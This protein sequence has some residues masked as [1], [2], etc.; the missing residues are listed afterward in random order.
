MNSFFPKG[1]LK[2]SQKLEAL[3]AQRHKKPSVVYLVTSAS[4][5][6]GPIH[7]FKLPIKSDSRIEMLPAVNLP[8]EEHPR[9]H[10]VNRLGEG[11]LTLAVNPTNGYLG[12]TFSGGYVFTNFW[13]TYAY[14]LHLKQSGFAVDWVFPIAVS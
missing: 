9:W 11:T 1:A 2:G 5:K 8:P 12:S 4:A 14:A 10:I 7:I 13:H 3:L 6:A